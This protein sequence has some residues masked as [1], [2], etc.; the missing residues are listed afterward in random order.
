MGVS[1]DYTPWLWWSGRLAGLIIVAARNHSYKSRYFDLSVDW[2]E[3]PADT[4]RWTNVVLMLGQRQRRWANI[5]TIFF[6]RI[7]SAGNLVYLL[8]S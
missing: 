7:V 4:R 2:T 8:N 5:K 3:N 6:Q 1:D